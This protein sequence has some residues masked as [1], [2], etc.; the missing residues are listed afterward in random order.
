M[1]T[2][3]PELLSSGF[4]TSQVGLSMSTLQKVIAEL[5][6]EPVTHINNIAHYSGADFE[7]IREYL[8]GKN[9]A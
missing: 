4:L 2:K 9:D 3:L 8:R 1:T 6:I 5:R 7:R